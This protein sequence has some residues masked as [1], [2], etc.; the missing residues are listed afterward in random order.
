MGYRYVTVCINSVNDASISFEN[1]VKFR[2]ETSE[3]TGLICER[4]VQHGQKTGEFSRI[5][6]DMLDRFSQSFHLKKALYD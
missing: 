4:Q 2:P 6:P 5:S 1:F 3:L